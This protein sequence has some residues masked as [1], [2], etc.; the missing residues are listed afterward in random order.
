MKLWIAGTR[1][2]VECDWALCTSLRDNV[3]HHLE[4]GRPSG[5]FPA[6]HALA[7]RCWAPASVSV[8]SRQ[9]RGEL[10]RARALESLPIGR[11]AMSIR[12]RAALTGA[13]VAPAVRGTELVRLVGW[14]AP[15]RV[16]G[17]TSLGNVLGDTMRRLLE[18]CAAAGDAA[19]ILV[20]APAAASRVAG[21]DAPPRLS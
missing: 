10:E 21:S 7:D 12:S 14:R 13:P 16:V 17:A 2:A 3:Q 9:L 18:F 5:T 15:V 11:L 1:L 6:I 4:G 20:G 19:V 8:E